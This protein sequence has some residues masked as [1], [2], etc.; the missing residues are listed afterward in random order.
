MKGMGALSFLRNSVLGTYRFY[1]QD[2]DEEESEYEIFS[3][4]NIWARAN[5]RHFGGKNVI[6]SLF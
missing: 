2:K 3:W 1:D 4:D 5:L 6:S